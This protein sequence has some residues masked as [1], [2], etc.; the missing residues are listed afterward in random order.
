MKEMI[1]GP[2]IKAAEPICINDPTTGELTTNIDK[3]KEISLKHNV[4]VSTKNILREQ[5][6]KELKDKEFPIK[7]QRQSITKINGN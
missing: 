1:N 5:D 3:I 4:N 6:S 2:N 7:R